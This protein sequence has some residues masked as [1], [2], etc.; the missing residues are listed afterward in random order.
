MSPLRDLL[1]AGALANARSFGGEDYVGFHTMMALAPSFHMSEQLPTD[2]AAL[3][4]PTGY[5]RGGAHVANAGYMVRADAWGGGVAG[6][7]CDHSLARAKELGVAVLEE[8]AFLA[9]LSE[10]PGA[11]ATPAPAQGNLL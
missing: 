2:D 5:V 7:M 10:S 3:P 8:A 6:A 9:R 1:T 4:I 11:L